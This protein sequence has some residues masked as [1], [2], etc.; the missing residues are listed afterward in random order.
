MGS[1]P[2]RSLLPLLL[3]PLSLLPVVC[4]D[5]GPLPSLSRAEPPEDIRH[6]NSFPVGSKV[7]YR[8]LQNLSKIPSRLDTIMCLNNSLWS[9]LQEFC[10]HSCQS[11]PQVAFAKLS[12]EDE[13]KN[14]YA[15]GITV[16][17]DCSPGYENSTA[18]LPTSTCRENS[19]WSEVPELCH[20]QSCGPPTN[21]EHGTVVAT[22]HLYLAR[23]KVVCNEGYTLSSRVSFILCFTQ[24]NGVAWTPLPTC[25][26]SPSVTGTTAVANS[27]PHL[28]KKASE[29]HYILPLVLIPCITG[30]AVIVAWSIKKCSASKKTG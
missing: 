26:V 15:V 21:P 28:E 6:K 8:C 23:A 19:T 12:K 5:C 20:K 27:T 18:E 11:P 4:G 25:Q 22:D 13:M 7:T 29:N 10:D 30:A 2:Y 14:F 16:S 3:S 24:G 9:N 17:Y 1:A